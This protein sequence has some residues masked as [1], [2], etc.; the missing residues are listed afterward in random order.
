MH[1]TMI[2]AFDHFTLLLPSLTFAMLAAV[3][4]SA[5]VSDI[6]TGPNLATLCRPL[7]IDRQPTTVTS[8]YHSPGRPLPCEELDLAQP[9]GRLKIHHKLT[10]KGCKSRLK[11]IA[12]PWANRRVEQSEAPIHGELGKRTA[13]KTS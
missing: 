6:D 1:R 10:V 13:R 3:D 5:R 12:K 8:E 9:W 11:T 2:K 4:G 7:P